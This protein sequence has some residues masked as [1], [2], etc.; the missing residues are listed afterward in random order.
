MVWQFFDI[1]TTLWRKNRMPFY[2][3]PG[4]RSL[5]L[6]C[7]LCLGIL[8]C[9]G[10][11]EQQGRESGRNFGARMNGEGPGSA[12]IPVQVATV[13]RGDISLF[14]LQTTSVEPVRQVSIIA[15]VSGQVSRLL[16]E[17]GDPVQK[18]TLLTQ[19]DEDEL[20]IQQVQA[21]VQMETDKATFE[22]SKKMLDENLI[23]EE[24]YETARLQYESSKAAYEAA[25]LQLNHT[26]VR[27]PIDGI[28]TLRHIELGQRVNAN[29]ALFDIADFTPL[30]AR[31]YVP[32]KDIGRIFVGQQAKIT[33]ESEPDT[34]FNGAVKMISPV[35]DPASGTAKVTI[36]IDDTKGKLRPGMF[37]SVFISTA[38]NKNTL[39]IPKKA[40]ILESE[41]DQ[42]FINESGVAKKVRIEVGFTSGDSIEVLSGLK[43]GDSVVTIGQEGLRT[44]LPLRIPGQ[45][46]EM[47]QAAPDSGQVVRVPSGGPPADGGGR[48]WGQPGGDSGGTPDPERLK[49]MEE[50]L[51]QNPEVKK[52]YDKRVKEDPDFKDNPEKKMA[53]FREQFQKMRGGG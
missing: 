10:D 31:I 36:D 49:R 33:I 39:L 27:S 34:D 12:A 5:L 48:G 26:S 22:R 35:V 37:A 46:P 28:V 52:E 20:V 42:V 9:N 16:V 2:E 14:L 8:A 1:V 44:G 41:D 29:E 3:E 11:A 50:R 30:R 25:T 40:L 24:A 13:R 45:E 4:L 15:K 21:K 51:L 38:T 17:E 53:F 6:P 19:L 7:V 18:G 23:A 47:T 43:E 32:E